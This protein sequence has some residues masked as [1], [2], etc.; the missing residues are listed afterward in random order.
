[1]RLRRKTQPQTRRQRLQSEEPSR[2]SS[3]FSYRSRRSD[4]SRETGRQVQYE[5]TKR[6]TAKLGRYWLQRFGILVLLIAIVASVFNILSLSSG[7]HVLPLTTSSSRSFLHPTSTYEAA[8]SKLLKASIWNSNKVTVNTAQ[9]RQSM[10]S[11]FPE[12][13]DVTVTVPLLAH[14]PLVYIEPAQPALIL[15]ATNGAFVV[16]NNGKALL[17]GSTPAELNQPSLPVLNDQSGLKIRLNHQALSAD[18]VKFMQTV[19]AQLVAKKL[20]VSGMTLPA[21]TS[22]LD[23]QVAGQPYFVKFNLQ[24]NN[25]RGQAGTLLATIDALKRQSITPSKYIDVRVDGR[26][27]YQ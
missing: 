24:S 9:I 22:E 18:N 3:S 23:V 13:T 16:D 6:R 17:L 21:S 26:A 5:A 12:L 10:L 20:A 7:A 1:M 19:L 2:P 25:A 8:A 14:R 27:Y 4:R 11:Q 15:V